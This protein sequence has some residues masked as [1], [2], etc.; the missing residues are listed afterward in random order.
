[1]AHWKSPEVIE[2]SRA[3]FGIN[4]SPQATRKNHTSRQKSYALPGFADAVRDSR[5]LARRRGGLRDLNHNES[6]DRRDSA[7][8]G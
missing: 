1:M 4:A 5:K 8:R 7:S 3:I 2:L 6:R